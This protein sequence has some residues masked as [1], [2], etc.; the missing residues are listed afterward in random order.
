MARVVGA[1]LTA[2]GVSLLLCSRD[3]RWSTWRVIVQHQIIAVSLVLVALFAL[4]G[5]TNNPQPSN[6]ST[7]LFAGSMALFLAAL[8]ALLIRMDIQP[9]RATMPTTTGI[10]H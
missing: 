7:W 2:P 3:A 8:L 5:T 10:D 6:L 1:F 4:L 9:G